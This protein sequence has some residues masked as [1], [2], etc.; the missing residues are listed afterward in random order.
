MR[1]TTSR[2]QFL[3]A[4]MTVAAGALVLPAGAVEPFVRTGPPRIRLALAA[5]SFRDDFAPGKDGTPARLDMF[6]FLDYCAEQ[7]CDG[8]ELTSYYFPEQVADAELAR[9]RRHAHVRGVTVSGTAVGNDFCLPP[10][11]KRTA[12]IA[13]VKEWIRKAAILGAPHIRVFAGS[14]HGQP[15]EVARRLCIEA[16]EDCAAEAGKHG[17]L[18]GIE[19]H[20]GIVAEAD[21]LLDIVRTVQSPWV[22][23]NLDTGNFHTDDPYADLAK[24]APYAVNVQFKGKISPRGQKQAGPADFARTFRIL[25]EAHYQGW[26]ALEYEMTE[27]PW[28]RVPA[29]LQEMRA[30][31]T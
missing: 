2:R 30:H 18:L 23:I 10:G 6:R 17:I 9:V 25:K 28:K 3:G 8:A 19:N 31:S 22:G 27:D 7:G 11:P 20:G 14:A 26:V 24:C 29:M 5:Y 13:D 4:G 12:D 16:L 15:P 21:A 1:I